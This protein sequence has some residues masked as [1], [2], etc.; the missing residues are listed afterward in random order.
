MENKKIE[1]QNPEVKDEELDIVSGGISRRPTQQQM[2]PCSMTGC[3]NQIPADKYPAY[4]DTC[5]EKM[6]KLGI[7]PI[8]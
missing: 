5:L 3:N 6:R 2:K 7:N 4:C 1:N 8:L